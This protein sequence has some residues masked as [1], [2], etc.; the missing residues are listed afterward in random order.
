M[1][2]AAGDAES[3]SPFQLSAEAP[4]SSGALFL[5]CS[6]R[7]ALS[8]GPTLSLLLTRSPAELDL[9]SPSTLRTGLRRRARAPLPSLAPESRTARS[10]G[11]S[12]RLAGTERRCRGGD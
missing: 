7:N 3:I 9:R 5:F 12:R 2:R 1:I 4:T 10:A 8:R 6:S 11:W